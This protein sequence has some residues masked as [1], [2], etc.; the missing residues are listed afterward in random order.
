MCF[1]WRDDYIKNPEEPE[2][3]EWYNFIGLLG[4]LTD[5]SIEIN[6]AGGEPLCDE[7]NL[8]L[9]SFSAKRGLRTSMPTNGFLIDEEMARKIANSGLGA[10]GISLDGISKNTHDFLRGREGCYDK[11]MRAIT[12]L[13]KR[14]GKLGIGILTT[15]SNQNLDEIVGLTEW[16][17]K[18]ERIGTIIFQA[19]AQ[20][21]NTIFDRQWYDKSEYSFL[22]P[23][24]SIKNHSIINNLI[25]FKKIRYKI[26]NPL[27]QLEAFKR[28]F[29]NPRE[30]IKK[31][32]CNVD[33]YMNINRFGDIFM[34]PLKKPIGN[35]KEG[36]PKKIWYSE[37]ANRLR[38]EIRNCRVNCHHLLNCCYEEEQEFL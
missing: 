25:R 21:F 11:V 38:E 12:Y 20:P 4:D 1:V 8:A 32:S 15:I 26:S 9:I 30:F 36:D 3:E 18:D 28:Y 7:R 10:I 27:S 29:D 35:I 33:F 19:I 34:C 13:D 5:N 2:L 23:R 16:V 37:D 24:D 14:R 17:N 22:W 31:T 6:V